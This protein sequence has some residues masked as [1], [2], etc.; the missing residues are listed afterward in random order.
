[1]IT[2]RSCIS[3]CAHGLQADQALQLYLAMQAAAAWQLFATMRSQELTPIVIAFSSLISACAKGELAEQALQLFVTMRSQRLTSEVNTYLSLIYGCA[4]N[5]LTGKPQDVWGP[6]PSSLPATI[7]PKASPRA[8][9]RTIRGE[10]VP[11]I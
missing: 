2:Y 7:S 3:A 6:T 1:M 4:K 10:P 8:P 11:P 9:P 5:E